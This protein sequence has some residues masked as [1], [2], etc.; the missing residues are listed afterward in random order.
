[1]ANYNQAVLSPHIPTL[2]LL[3]GVH[4]THVKTGTAKTFDPAVGGGII[5]SA[6]TWPPCLL[7]ILVKEILFNLPALPCYETLEK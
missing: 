4:A 7:Y 1:M 6:F 3:P 2:R 5:M